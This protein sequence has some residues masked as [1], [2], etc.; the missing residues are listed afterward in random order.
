MRKFRAFYSLHS[1]QVSQ[2]HWEL[3]PDKIVIKKT[4]VRPPTGIAMACMFNIH[5]HTYGGNMPLLPKLLVWIP[6]HQWILYKY[7]LSLPE[8][9]DS[10]G[11]DPGLLLHHGVNSEIHKYRWQRCPRKQDTSKTLFKVGQSGPLSL[12]HSFRYQKRLRS[13]ELPLFVSSILKYVLKLCQ[14]KRGR[15]CMQEWRVRAE[16]CFNTNNGSHQQMLAA[17]YF[18]IQKLYPNKKD[19]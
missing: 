15:D 17:N 4:L 5:S 1:T 10:I 7:S 3:L 11:W 13:P 19:G 12:Q 16:H 14:W 2:L 8:S 18:H 6:S 9:K